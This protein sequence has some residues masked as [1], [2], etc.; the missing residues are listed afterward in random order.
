M[1]WQ[2]KATKDVADCD[3]PRGAVEQALIRGSLNGVTHPME[4]RVSGSQSI[5]SRS[6]PGEVKHLSTPRK[7]NQSTQC[8]RLSALHK[9]LSDGIGDSPSS[10]ERKGKS[11]NPVIFHRGL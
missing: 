3:K 8:H 2:L 6:E 10:G 9:H 4:D 7:R 1:P 5:T 11:P